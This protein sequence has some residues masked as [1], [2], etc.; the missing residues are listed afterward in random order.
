MGVPVKAVGSDWRQIRKDLVAKG[1]A[2]KKK[3]NGKWCLVLLADV[4]FDNPKIAAQVILGRDDATGDM[5]CGLAALGIQ[6]IVAIIGDSTFFHSGI[7]PLIEAVRQGLCLTVLLLDN[8]TTA[9]TGGQEVPH[10]PTSTDRQCRVDLVALLKSL[11]IQRCTG[12][13]PHK[14]GE[15]EIQKL[16]EDSFHEKGVKVLLYRSPCQL[17]SP[18]YGRN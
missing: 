13:D 10:G 8:G 7:P 16:I 4:H 15:H 9:M 2:V 6:R 1:V 14:L 11:G 12:F 5:A 3:I 18:Q 17:Y